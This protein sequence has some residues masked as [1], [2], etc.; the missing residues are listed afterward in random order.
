MRSGRPEGARELSIDPVRVVVIDDDPKSLELVRAIVE[1]PGVEIVTVD[2]PEVGFETV[3]RLRPEVV[4][5]D[6]MMPRI[7]GLELLDRIV[8]FDPAIDVILI[9]AHYS[10]ESAVE[11]IQRGATDYLN[12]P[13]S[14]ERV[15]TRLDG[16]IADAR[17]RHQA[18][19][20]DEDLLAASSFENMVGRNPLMLEAFAKIRRVAPHFRTALITGPTGT[21]K[22]LVARALHNLSPVASG[23]FVVCNCA[24]LPDTLIESELFGYQRGAFTGAMT[25]KEGLIET[26]HQGVLFLDEIG[27]L[28]VMS[29]AKLLR[30]IQNQ[31]I[32]RLGSNTARKVNVRIVAATNRPLRTLIGARGFREDLYFRLAMVEIKLPSLAQRK[33]DLPLLI[34]H[35][36]EYFSKHYGKQVDGLTVRA[37]TLLSRYDWP[38]NIRE[39]ENAIGYAAM[40]TDSTKIDVPDLPESLRAGAAASEEPGAGSYPMVTVR[41]MEKIHARKILDLVGG[42]KVRAAQVL[43][44]SRA[45]LYRLLSRRKPGLGE[46]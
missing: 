17:R 27:E 41:E 46:Q 14:I 11:A 43:G 42:D 8:E 36:V 5:L 22:E 40:M 28:P 35:F 24:A 15:K 34:R 25:D 38:G 10:T 12:K 2:S 32:Q 26:A 39:L 20:L 23:P 13:L 9:T 31:E 18:N 33:Q 1:Q 6:L 37:E 30:V 16:L 7:S 19:R 29:Q 3:R 44:V 4:M 21:G 45:T